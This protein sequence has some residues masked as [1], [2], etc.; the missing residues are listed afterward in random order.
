MSRLELS[1]NGLKYKVIIPN[2]NIIV[3]IN[4]CNEIAH[5]MDHSKP[6]QY[7]LYPR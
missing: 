7:I 5:R 4:S 1:H 6:K 2:G 3:K